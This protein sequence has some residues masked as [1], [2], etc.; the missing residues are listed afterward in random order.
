MTA[1]TLTA[2]PKAGAWQGLAQVAPVLLA[3]T[4]LLLA[5]FWKEGST[6]V[7]VW[8]VS[9]AYSHCF[10]VL[11]IAAY[12]AWDRRDRLRG[13]RAEPLPWLA[14]G[15]IPLGFAWLAAERL[16]IMEG[17]QLVAMTILQLL[18]LAVLGW[19]LWWALSAALLYLYFLVPFGAFVTPWLQHFTAQFIPVGLNLLGIPNY[20]DNFLI[21]I[22]EGRFY[23][24]E[25]CAGL[26]FLIA[27]IAFGVLYSVLI[28]RSPWRRAGF[29]LASV[30]IPIIA[31]G[32]RA[33]GIV[34]LG[35]ILGSAQA[36]AADHIIYGWLFFSVVILLLILAGMPFRED[37]PGPA[38]IRTR[39]PAAGP[40]ALPPMRSLW[41]AAGLLCALTLLAPAMALGLDRQAGSVRETAAP[42]F[43]VTTPCGLTPGIIPAAASLAPGRGTTTTYSCGPMTLAV[44]VLAVPPRSIQGPIQAARHALGVE[45]GGGE[46]ESGT[47]HIP[48]GDPAAWR[49]VESEDTLH[50]TA[51]T[52]WVGGD[53]ARG[54][55]GARL[56]QLRDSILGSS[57]APVLVV[58]DARLPRERAEHFQRQPARALLQNFLAAQFDLSAQIRQIAAEAAGPR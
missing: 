52:I 15:A 32:I 49:I 42:R 9:T 57:L 26:R 23:V 17:R 43:V 56:R 39:E 55:I 35:H 54:G 58:L 40:S 13:M 45:S 18:F 10:F 12:I 41:V 4:V 34:V 48:N 46:V 22:P 19:R 7:Q 33:L 53:V 28:Y 21:E 11:P 51:S 3:G 24:A 2:W 5:V 30:I 50:A 1:R 37:L 8:S 27:A 47:L 38:A 44:T 14:L 31:N 6:A 16:G 29:M 25:A 20:V 36:G